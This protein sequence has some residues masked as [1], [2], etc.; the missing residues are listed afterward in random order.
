MIAAGILPRR[1]PFG[2]QI[3]RTLGRNQRQRRR[4]KD[5]A[6]PR[7]SATRRD[8]CDRHLS[9]ADGYVGCSAR[10]RSG[11]RLPVSGYEQYSNW[12]RDHLLFE[13][14]HQ[15]STPAGPKS[16]GPAAG[17][18]GFPA[19]AQRPHTARAHHYANKSG[20]RLQV[21]C[22]PIAGSGNTSPE[23]SYIVYSLHDL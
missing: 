16:R 12:P 8:A 5:P 17:Q 10:R 15:A 23:R 1:A 9:L 20:R 4:Q 21:P 7:V 22:T 13:V 14:E 2:E 11:D 3:E 18:P 6:A 19:A